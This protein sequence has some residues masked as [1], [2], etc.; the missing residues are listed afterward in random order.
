MRTYGL[1]LLAII[2]L[3]PIGS[4]ADGTLKCGIKPIPKIHLLFVKL[5]R[6]S[7]WMIVPGG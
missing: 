2:L 7:K 5:L 6:M 3:L 4:S 1:A